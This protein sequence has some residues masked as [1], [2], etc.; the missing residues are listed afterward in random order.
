MG[1]RALFVRGLW[2]QDLAGFRVN[3]VG[4]DLPIGLGG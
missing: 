4:F 2:G 3:L 1:D